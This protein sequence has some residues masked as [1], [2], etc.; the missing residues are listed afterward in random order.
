MWAKQLKKKRF[1][2]RE[3]P[4]TLSA[5]PVTRNGCAK[6]KRRDFVSGLALAAGAT[7]CTRQQA[8]CGP[9]DAPSRETF[10]W[11]LV[12]SWPPGLPGLGV[13]VENLAERIEKATSGRL[14][15]KVFAGGELVPALE[16]LDAVRSLDK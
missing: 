16:V 10:E 3:R 7:A 9:G 15:I 11:N 14:K 8:E 5:Q 2:A 1:A 4:T 6:M 13:G 12:T